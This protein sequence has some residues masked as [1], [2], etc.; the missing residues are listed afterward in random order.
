LKKKNVKI[1]LL[2]PTPIVFIDLG[3]ELSKIEKDAIT[4]FKN[5]TYK[6]IGNITTKDSYVL[7]K[8]PL[9]YNHRILE[10]NACKW[11]QIIYKDINNGT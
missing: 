2:F 3:R 7:F 6:N 5:E 10:K 1:E 9:E 11:A 4:Q 8:P